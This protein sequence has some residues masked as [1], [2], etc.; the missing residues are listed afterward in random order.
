MI[1]N[2]CVSWSGDGHHDH[3]TILFTEKISA[4]DASAPVYFFPF[5]TPPCLSFRVTSRAPVKGEDALGGWTEDQ[6][7]G[8]LLLGPT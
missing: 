3:V 6:C 2:I 1:R 7:V 5:S 8:S 4:G